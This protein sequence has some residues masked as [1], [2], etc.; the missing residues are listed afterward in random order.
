MGITLSVP[1]GYEPSEEVRKLPEDFRDMV[2]FCIEKALE[3]GVTGYARLRRLVYGEW[4]SRWNYS[5]HFCHSA[6]RVA[7]SMLK[8]WRRMLNRRLHSWNFRRLQFYIEYKARLEGLP[9]VYI[10]PKGTS[11]LCPVCGG[12]LAPNGHGLVKCVQPH[13]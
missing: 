2:N 4:K 13:A 6:V 12:R 1:F 8:S 5:T 7:T 9:V 10:N 3:S 11:S